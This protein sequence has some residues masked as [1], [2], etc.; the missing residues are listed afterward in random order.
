MEKPHV[1]LF[2]YELS[3]CRG[4][5]LQ[6]P[7]KVSR[8]ALVT[9]AGISCSLP[10]AVQTTAGRKGDVQARKASQGGQGRIRH[11]ARQIPAWRRLLTALFPA[12]LSQVTA[13]ALNT[14]TKR[15]GAGLKGVLVL[16]HP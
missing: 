3:V 16:K 2:Y 10:M 1:R 7:S 6:H 14:G 4:T 12:V 8:A 13:L 9:P 11:K 5:A 15:L